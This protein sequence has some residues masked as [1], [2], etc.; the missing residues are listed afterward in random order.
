MVGTLPVLAFRENDLVLR[1]ALADSFML[2]AR[3][4]ARFLGASAASTDNV[5]IW[6]LGGSPAHHLPQMRRV[7]VLA[8]YADLHLNGSRLPPDD[9]ELVALTAYSGAMLLYQ[10]AKDLLELTDLTIEDLV[11][12]QALREQLSFALR[13]VWPALRETDPFG[14]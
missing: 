11:D 6:D 14:A 10:G 7:R 13:R 2:H 3:I 4:L 9:L 8:R 12:D 1:T 5:T